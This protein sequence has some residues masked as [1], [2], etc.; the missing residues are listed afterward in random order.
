MA[1][2]LPEDITKAWERNPKEGKKEQTGNCG[3]AEGKT[4]QKE[5]REE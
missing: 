3:G 4:E 5:T 2:K 1:K